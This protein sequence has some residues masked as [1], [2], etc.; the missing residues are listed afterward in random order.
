MEQLLTKTVE[1]PSFK[2]YPLIV[3]KRY[4]NSVNKKV[5]K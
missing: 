3:V 1:F 2:K 4:P 5:G